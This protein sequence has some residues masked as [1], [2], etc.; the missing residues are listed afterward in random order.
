LLKIG[1]VL[2]KISSELNIEQIQPFTSWTPPQIA[3][4]SRI[5][6][7]SIDFISDANY[8]LK[9]FLIKNIAGVRDFADVE[10]R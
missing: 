6:N 2:E 1:Y 8:E 7:S 5:V 4:A 9:D 3:T 10:L